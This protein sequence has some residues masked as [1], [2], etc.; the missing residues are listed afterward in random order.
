MA[1]FFYARAGPRPIVL[2][3][4]AQRVNPNVVITVENPATGYLKCFRPWQDAVQ[5]LGLT[6]IE[7][8]YCKFGAEHRKAKTIWTNCKGM[9]RDAA[10]GRDAGREDSNGASD[11][12]DLGERWETGEDGGGGA[13]VRSRAGEL[14]R[15]GRGR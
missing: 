13:R 8:T 3:K 15:W 1:G 7:V 6:P 4:E 9:I 5:A 10:G 14:G 2:L 11:S 12:R